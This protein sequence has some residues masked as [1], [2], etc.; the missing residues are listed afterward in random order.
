MTARRRLAG[1]TWRF[2]AH[3]APAVGS[4]WYGAPIELRSSNFEPSVFDELV[5]DRWLHVEQMD[6]GLWWMRLGG[7]HFNIRVD[8]DGRAVRVSDFDGN[9]YPTEEVAT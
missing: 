9:E 7:T 1:T 5:V 4:R 8:R 6:S 2:L 3:G